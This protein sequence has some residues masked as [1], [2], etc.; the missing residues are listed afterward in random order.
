[1]EFA[2]VREKDVDVLLSKQRRGYEGTVKKMKKEL[3]TLQA[4]N[5]ELQQQARGKRE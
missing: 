1:M 4:R 2:A 5:E 3:L